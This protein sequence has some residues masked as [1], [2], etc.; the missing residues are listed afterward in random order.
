MDINGIKKFTGNFKVAELKQ[1]AKYIL[2]ETKTIL[3]EADSFESTPK[4]APA[5][6]K[7]IIKNL[8]SKNP[9][10]KKINSAKQKANIAIKNIKQ[11]DGTNPIVEIFKPITKNIT[12][13]PISSFKVAINNENI[14]KS[15]S[16][17]N[18]LSRNTTL[19][20]LF[21]NKNSTLDNIVKISFEGLGVGPVKILQTLSSDEKSLAKFTPELKSV[22]TELRSNCTPTRTL[23]QAQA[24]ANKIFGTKYKIEKLLGVG[25]IGEAYLCKTNKG[26]NVVVK[27]IKKN[28]TEEQLN[29]EKKLI[30]SVIDSFCFDQKKKDYAQVTINNL[31]EGWKKELDFNFEK[32]GAVNLAQGAKNFKVANVLDLGT[33]KTSKN[34]TGIVYELAEGISLDKI[35]TMC[36]TFKENPTKYLN[37]YKDEIKTHAWLK[38]PSDWLKELPKSYFKAIN[39]MNFIPKGDV[40]FSHGDPHAGNVF[41]NFDEKSKKIIPT[42]I[43]AGLTVKRSRKQTAENISYMTNYLIGNSKELAKKLLDKAS[44]VPTNKTYD[45]LIDSI[46]TELNKKLFKSG[47]NIR[48]FGNNQ[49][50]IDSILD[51]KGIILSGEEAVFSKAQLQGIATGNELCKLANTPFEPSMIINDVKEGLMQSLKKDFKYTAKQL[52]SPIAHVVKNTED[53]LSV[54]FQFTYKNTP[55]N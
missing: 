43:D 3:Q 20:H 31:Y 28:V 55:T 50:I 27:M 51:K 15:Y 53:S 11:F 37:E 6:K 24:Y 23:N 39:E 4:F 2:K 52:L 26:K 30:S 48:N 10:S 40:I 33:E 22:L 46:S 36:K 14:V 17:Y 13:D 29:T 19:N 44:F 7:S 41:I 25:S 47:Y 21:V 5:Q 54:L 1:E 12:S 42:F 38:N 8:L 9:V 32:E 49:K 45:E 35:I 18:E 16:K 34:A